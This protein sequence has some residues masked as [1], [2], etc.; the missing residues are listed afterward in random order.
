ME[1]A[2]GGGECWLELPGSLTDLSYDGATGVCFVDVH[3]GV[4]TGAHT[5]SRDCETGISVTLS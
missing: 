3:S 5:G 2:G 1:S 4:C